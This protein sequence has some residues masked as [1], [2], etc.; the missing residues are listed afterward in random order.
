MCRSAVAAA[1]AAAG[2]K[3]ETETETQT[4][5]QTDRQT[6]GSAAWTVLSRI[7]YT[8]VY[9]STDGKQVRSS[10][11]VTLQ[12]NQTDNSIRRPAADLFNTA[13]N[14]RINYLTG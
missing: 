2:N 7:D 13:A 4:Q 8:N 3:Y 6:D 1:A 5:T 11:T 14:L 12:H 10:A 9:L